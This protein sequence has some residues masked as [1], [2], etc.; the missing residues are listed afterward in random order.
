MFGTPLNLR[1]RRLAPKILDKVPIPVSG[2]VSVQ[3]R[4]P[5]FKMPNMG[6]FP[7]V[8]RP[9]LPLRCPLNGSRQL[10]PL[11]CTA[12]PLR[13]MDRRFAQSLKIAGSCAPVHP[14]RR[15]RRAGGCPRY[16]AFNSRFCLYRKQSAFPH[17]AILDQIR[18]LGKP[19][20]K[21]AR[22]AIFRPDIVDAP[23]F[24]D[25]LFLCK[26]DN[27]LSAF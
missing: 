17:Y 25:P 26:T 23:P 15:Y 14:D 10:Q 12:C 27:A 19:L 3:T 7:L 21:L 16:K 4:P 24:F 6:T 5:H 18:Y 13:H 9:R 11:S 22:I 2:T 8:P 1:R 20:F